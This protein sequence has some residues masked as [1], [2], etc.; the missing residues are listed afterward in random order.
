MRKHFSAILLCFIFAFT[1][2]SW[3]SAQSTTVKDI[4]GNIY[5]QLTIGTQTWLK[6]NLRTT[7]FNDGTPV[8]RVTGNKEWGGRTSPGYCWYNNDSTSNSGIYGALYNWYAVA[9]KKLCP[10][11]WHIPGDADYTVLENTLGGSNEA[12][13]KMK[14]KGTSHWQSFD[15]GSTNESAFSLRPS[16]YR[17]SNGSFTGMGLYCFL[18]TTSECFSGIEEYYTRFAWGRYLCYYNSLVHRY[19]FEKKYGFSVRCLKDTI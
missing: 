8:P 12:G 3:T 13:S 16:G 11:G 19:Y 18:W 7:R 5:T 15:T 2:C 10:A 1:I 9:E 17:L 14:E 6:E 4:D